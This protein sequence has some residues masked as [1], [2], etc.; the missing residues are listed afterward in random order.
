MNIVDHHV[1]ALQKVAQRIH[2]ACLFDQSVW[3]YSFHLTPRYDKS[4]LDTNAPLV[5]QYAA[6]L[7]FYGSFKRNRFCFSYLYKRTSL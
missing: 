7:F 6:A 5:S 3:T 1:E 4:R 2:Q